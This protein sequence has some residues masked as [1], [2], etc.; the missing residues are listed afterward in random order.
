MSDETTTTDGDTEV[1]AMLEEAR[2]DLLFY[3]Q[4]CN[5]DYIASKFHIFLANKLQQVA[6]GKIKRLI[7]TCPPRVGKSRLIAVEFPTWLLGRKP[8]TEIV[9]ASYAQDLSMSHS[10]QARARLASDEYAAIFN[11]RIADGEAAANEW[12]TS[13]GGMYKA[14]GVGGGLTGRGCNCLLVDDSTKDFQ[15]AHS[16]TIRDNVWNWFQAVALTRLHPGASVIVL[17]TRWHTDDLV[18]RLLDPA[19]CN[20]ADVATDEKWEIINLPAMAHDD[21]PLGR[22]PGDALF[23]ERYPV[24]R[25]RSIRASVGSY[26]WSALYDGSPVVRGGNYIPVANLQ[27]VDAAPEGLRWVRFWDLATSEKKTSD[28]TSSFAAALDTEG[29]LYLRDWIDGQWEWPESRRRIKQTAELEGIPVGIEA[30]AGFK[31]A[32]ANLIEVLPSH[33]TCREYGADRDKL[34]RALPWIAM[35]DRGKV[36]LVRGAWNMDFIMQ[37]EQF[38]SGKLDDGVDAVSGCWMMLKTVFNLPSAVN[39]HDRLH[40]AMAQRRERALAG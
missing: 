2:N 21:D 17:Q 25:L 24:E 26:V 22:A 36:A 18:G 7:V 8:E 33:I 4:A 20:E 15:E 16:A 10:K 28:H 29:T 27:I 23:P 1:S 32:F 5:P 37:A 9:L 6:E 12:K 39:V 11:T 30:V 13:H 14:V 31:T 35:V 3:T 40:R 19:R 34:T 38:P